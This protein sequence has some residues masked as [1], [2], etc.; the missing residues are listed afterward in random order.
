MAVS[1]EVRRFLDNLATESV[2][3]A[4]VVTAPIAEFI[5]TTEARNTKDLVQAQRLAR[6]AGISDRFIQLA[7]SGEQPEVEADAEMARMRSRFE[8]TVAESQELEAARQSASDVESAINQAGGDVAIKRNP[9]GTPVIDLMGGFVVEGDV[10]G[11]TMAIDPETGQMRV[12]FLPEE[13]EGPPLIGGFPSDYKIDEPEADRRLAAAQELMG[14]R[15]PGMPS[16]DDVIGATPRYFEFDQWRDFATKSPE[17]QTI[18]QQQLVDAGLLRESDF[19]P[20]VW[21]YEAARAMEI[22]MAESNATSGRRSWVDVLRDRIE[23]REE[24]GLS[25]EA[26]QL[27]ASRRLAL[28]AFREPDYASLSQNVK[29]LFR[30]QLGRDPADWEVALLADQLNA[31]YRSAYDADIRA[32]TAEFEAGNRAIIESDETGEAAITSAGTVAAVDPVARLRQRF[33]E[34]YASEFELNEDRM[35]ERQNLSNVFSIL[36]KTNNLMSGGVA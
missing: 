2:R 18:V 8:S 28:P 5:A 21:T 3:Q 30:N 29:D 1:D 19:V 13:P 15:R 26:E 10:G 17:Y 14:V 7:L 24:A 25:E 9:D 31:D 11:Q 22:A 32:L 16:F 33:E 20:G 36:T 34:K 27:L 4:G 35:A 12:A 6:Q 23:G